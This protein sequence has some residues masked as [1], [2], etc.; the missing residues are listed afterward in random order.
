MPFNTRNSFQR[1]RERERE[2]DKRRYRLTVFRAGWFVTILPGEFNPLP[3]NIEFDSWGR[4]TGLERRTQNA[5][6][7]RIVAQ[8]R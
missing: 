2:R 7:L 6:V 8:L 1:E 5:L 4:M 3:C